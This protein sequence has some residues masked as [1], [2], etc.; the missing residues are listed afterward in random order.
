[1]MK[2]DGMMEADM[3]GNGTALEGMM[4]VAS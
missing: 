1:M 4:M 3:N 2:E